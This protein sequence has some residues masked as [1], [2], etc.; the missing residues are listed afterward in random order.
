LPPHRDFASVRHA[1]GVADSTPTLF[2]GFVVELVE[3]GL[4]EKHLLGGLEVNAMLA[5]VLC[6]IV[7]VHEEVG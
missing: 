6:R 4:V 7:G 5:E 2:A 1:G 3:A